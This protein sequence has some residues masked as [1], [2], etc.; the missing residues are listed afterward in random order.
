MITATVKNGSTNLDF[1]PW[2]RILRHEPS[3]DES[4][5]GAHMGDVFAI[6][7]VHKDFLQDYL[8]HH[9]IPFA[10]LFKERAHRHHEELATGKGF[11]P[12]MARSDWDYVESRLQPRELSPPPPHEHVPP[13]EDAPTGG[14]PSAS[15]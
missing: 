9:V 10:E 2:V 7:V 12:G 1:T 4:G 11:V 6:E 5:F 15:D 3:P 8:T 13:E 14:P